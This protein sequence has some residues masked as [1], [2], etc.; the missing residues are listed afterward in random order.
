MTLRTLIAEKKKKK[1]SKKKEVVEEAP[2]PEP[3]PA[4]PAPAPAEEE[5]PPKISDGKL[6]LKYSEILPP[7]FSPDA[8]VNT[9]DLRAFSHAWQN[10]KFPRMS[11]HISK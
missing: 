2:P 3:E 8:L 4:A 10:I 6:I 5:W 7:L 1:K 9:P 11:I